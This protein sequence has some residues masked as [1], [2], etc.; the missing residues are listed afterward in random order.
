MP[1]P[2]ELSPPLLQLASQLQIRP[3]D[4]REQFIRGGGHGGQKINKTSSQVLLKHE[5]TGIEVRCQDFREQSKNRL[6]AY[7]RLILKVEELV[8]GQESRLAREKFK[9][10]KQKQRRNRRSKERMLEEKKRR[11]EIKEGRRP[12]F[13]GH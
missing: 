6:R 13:S 4:V 1:W 5:P 3:E 10:R 12:P 11:G 7:E 2:V 9:I 8:R